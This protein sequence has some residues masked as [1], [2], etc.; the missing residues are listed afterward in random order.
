MT[1][2]RVIREVH[3]RFSSFTLALHLIRDS[4]LARRRHA[5]FI[6][7]DFGYSLQDFLSSS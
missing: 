3:Q 1:V 6:F 5:G 2:T 4:E 7:S